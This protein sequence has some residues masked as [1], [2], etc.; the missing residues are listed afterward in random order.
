MKIKLGVI[1]AVIFVFSLLSFEAVFAKN[2]KSHGNSKSEKK[3]SEEKT[4]ESKDSKTPPGWSK[5]K[6]VGWH[7]KGYPPGWSKWEKSKQDK[8]VADRDLAHA[9][10]ERYIVK[11]GVPEKN[12]D[13]IQQA[14]ENVIAS[15]MVI[16]D[17][18][19]KIVDAMK[20]EKKRKLLMID[21]MQTALEFMK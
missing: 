19:N 14:I 3:F 12:G 6:K 1:F 11:Y 5:G 10:V 17:A 18:K 15:G 9:E 4:K 2:D 7:N 21:T 20:D 13:E 16:N 8:W